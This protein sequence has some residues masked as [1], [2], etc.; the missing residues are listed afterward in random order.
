MSKF[1]DN[2]NNN[3]LLHGLPLDISWEQ[4]MQRLVMLAH[5]AAV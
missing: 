5:G 2:I 4:L 3:P 1:E